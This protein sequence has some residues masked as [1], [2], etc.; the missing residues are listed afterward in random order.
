MSS[1]RTPF[2][3]G[4][5]VL[6]EDGIVVVLTAGPKGAG[7]RYTDGTLGHI[8]WTDVSLALEVNDGEIAAM[9]ESLRPRWDGLDEDVKDQALF[10]L[11]V[12]QEVLTGYCEGHA[13]LAREGEPRAP[14]GPNSTMSESRRCR[15]MAELLTVE[16]Q[17]ARRHERH[18]QKGRPDSLGYSVSTIRLWVREFRRNGLLALIDGR[19]IRKKRGWDLIDERFRALALQEA[20][21]LDGDRSTISQNE[22]DRRVRVALKEAGAQDVV[23]PERITRQYLSALMH[24][25]GSTTRAQK[26]RVLRSV[27]GTQEYPAY[28]PG[29]VVA[30][31]ATRADNLVYDPLSGAPYS[32]EILAAICVATRVL[33]ALRVVPRSANA[34][35]AGLLIYDVCRPFSC[36]VEGKS[37]G[38]WRWGGLPQQLDLTELG[39]RTGRQTVSPDYSTLQ[40]E[41]R[42]PGVRPDAVHYDRGSIFVSVP[43]RA[44]LS[45]LQIDLLLNRGGKA[46]D[47]PHIERWW[48]TI[49]RGVQQIPGYKGRNTSQRGRLV[50]DEALVT[51]QELQTHLRGFVALDYHRERHTGHI[52]PGVDVK[53]AKLGPLDMW[54]AM[55]EATGRI[56]VPQHPDLIYQ[57]L[58]VRWGTISHAGVEF[59]N[60]TYDSPAL[61]SYRDVPVGTFRSRDKAAPFFVD[62]QDLSRI[63]FKDPDSDGGPITPV[64]WRGAGR[65]DAPMTSL[66]VA[67]ALGGI[68]RRGGNNVLN[69]GSATRQ[70]IEELGQI[71]ASTRPAVRKMVA[72]AEQ[73]VEQSRIDHD[74][75]EQASEM[76]KTV[77]STQAKAKAKA[78]PLSQPW[79]NFLDG[80]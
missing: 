72:R 77:R 70:I 53:K 80:E 54:D 4:Q 49:Q 57:F 76:L 48:E 41:H 68:R 75:A 18:P 8:P 13:A 3:R 31:D 16:A 73:R 74:E 33:L 21:M 27:S 19:R 15:H 9:T 32:V 20:D 26:S 6:T 29:Q 39:L 22:L 62:P 1:G 36:V 52:L 50:A 61:G 43:H 78:K 23:T 67:T 60:M 37:I 10:K 69:Y 25:R 28:K 42:I 17:H 40:G 38:P 64:P 7:V 55:I 11:S 2:C 46:N 66:I 47:N 79:P 34:M 63:W 24:E 12:V 35:E 59:D 30:I 51:A 45:D 44:L 56:D 58:P 65:I 5:A 14:F 71:T